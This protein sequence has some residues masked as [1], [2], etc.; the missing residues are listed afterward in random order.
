MCIKTSAKIYFR[1]SIS[2][3]KRVEFDAVLNNHLRT[4]HTSIQALEQAL[5]A[6]DAMTGI[7][8]TR[9]ADPTRQKSTADHIWNRVKTFGDLFS[10]KKIKPE[11][12]TDRGIYATAIAGIGWLGYKVFGGGNDENTS[13]VDTGKTL[14]DYATVQNGLV[15]GSVVAAAVAAK[16]LLCTK[17]SSETAEESSENHFRST[18]TGKN[19][20]KESFW[21]RN[22]TMIIVG[23]IAVVSIAGIVI[24]IMFFRKGRSVH[25]VHPAEDMV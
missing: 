14:K 21:Q 19:N 13:Y 11:T 12:W 25:F 20:R 8:D 4:S 2:E 24:Y 7:R 5:A 16:T 22:Q 3:E 1:S 23:G 18:N 10:W 17:E 6:D 9:T 15:A